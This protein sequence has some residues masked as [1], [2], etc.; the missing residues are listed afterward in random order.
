MAKIRWVNPVSADFN[1][2][3]DWSRGRVP[4]PAD[5]AILG[6]LGATAY[7]VTATTAEAVG[8]I[9]LGS[10]ATLEIAAGAFT[11]SAGTGSASGS[12][13]NA[14]VIQID[15]KAVFAVGGAI[16]N[17]GAITLNSLGAGA[18]ITL[19]ADTTL[20]GAG[21][22]TLNHHANNLI[23]GVTAA[24][25]LTNIDN[26]IS[27]SGQLGDGQMTF[28]N[29][30]AGV[31]DA[32]GAQALTVD[33]GTNAI[34]NAG[35]MEA[36]RGGFL[37]IGSA[38]EGKGGEIFADAGS[39]VEIMADVTGGR[40]DT[41]RTAT[42]SGT[43][44]LDFGVT[45]T[46]K[47]TLSNA[48][49]I[50]LGGLGAVAPT[51]LAFKTAA[52]LVGGGTIF[53]Q[54]KGLITGAKPGAVLT[55]VDNTLAGSGDI[56]AGRL[57]LINDAAGVIRPVG[58]LT[59]NTGANTI[60]NAGTIETLGGG[61]L[62][63]KSAVANTGVIEA[64]GGTLTLDA[65]VTGS[66]AVE[67]AAGTLDIANAGAAEA[68]AFTGKR[69]KLELDQS[70]TYG[71]AVSGF[72]SK[73]KTK[74]DLR[75]IGFVGSGEA[76]YSGDKAGGVLTVT[77]GTHTAA[78]DLVGAY[79]TAVF[80]AADDGHGGTVVTA[81]RPGAA[82]APVHRLAQAMA[83]LGPASPPGAHASAEPWRASLSMLAASRG[84]VA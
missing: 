75:D 43:I 39:F 45:A 83:G 15:N 6:A 49:S 60:T 73:G 58:D 44:L 63:V 12:G 40:L 3:A 62:E 55:N 68:V 52:T 7:T 77:D 8:S 1:I 80:T 29:Q 79:R 4:G 11:A 14:G 24:T 61:K 28:V 33:T 70:Q 65:A 9:Q 35:L 13:A 46:V 78:I 27:G 31:V 16:D 30:A 2:A 22:V 76:T 81:A 64:G 37:T 57:I 51:R 42:A 53:L 20:S 74:L 25:V 17:I 48:G 59:L 71:G 26:T 47:G 19:I 50:E 23:L 21:H 84:H 69:G 54:G 5:A 32:T 66:G 56:G 67:I 10:T 36:T 34:A 41:A 72:S 18:E 38:I 82:A